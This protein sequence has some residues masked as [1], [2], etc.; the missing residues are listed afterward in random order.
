MVQVFYGPSVIP[1]GTPA[2]TA[3]QVE[4]WSLTSVGGVGCV[5]AWATWL[6][7]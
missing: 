2:K 5:L 4:D 6:E 1:F 3:D 7:C